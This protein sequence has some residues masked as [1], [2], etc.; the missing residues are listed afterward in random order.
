[1]TV[2]YY[3]FVITLDKIEFTTQVYTSE[4]TETKVII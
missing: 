3:F 4:I 2:E 1:M